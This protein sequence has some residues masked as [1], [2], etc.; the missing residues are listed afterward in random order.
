MMQT[1]TND[2][3]MTKELTLQEPQAEAPEKRPN[4]KRFKRKEWRAMKVRAPHPDGDKGIGDYEVQ[5]DGTVY[6][7][8]K[9]QLRRIKDRQLIAG[10]Q[11]ELNKAAA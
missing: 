11:A 3:Q 4:G 1:L 7:R 2:K 10:V 6:L 9:G 5:R 8:V